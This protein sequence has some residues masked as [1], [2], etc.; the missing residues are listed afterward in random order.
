MPEVSLPGMAFLAR[1]SKKQGSNVVEL[2][3]RGDS[4]SA[5]DVGAKVTESSILSALKHACTEA[6]IE[7]QIT[8]A[9]LSKVASDLF[10]Q[11]GLGEGKLLVPQE[12]EL[13]EESSELDRKL[14][15]I[16]SSLQ[17]LHKKVDALETRL[18]LK[19]AGE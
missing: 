14:A 3:F 2:I 11:A 1:L 8:P 6:D 10:K 9:A 7:H 19:Q 15:I 4:I 5:V 16:I 12:F 17:K 13:S 18:E